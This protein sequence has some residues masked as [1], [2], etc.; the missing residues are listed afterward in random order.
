MSKTKTFGH[1]QI[2]NLLPANI[3]RGCELRKGCKKKWE[4][5]PS[6]QCN[7]LQIVEKIVEESRPDSLIQSGDKK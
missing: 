4:T 2:L 1:T 7:G 5:H 3:C 6:F